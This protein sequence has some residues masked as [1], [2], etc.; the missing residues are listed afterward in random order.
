[1]SEQN[2]SFRDTTSG[3]NGSP[4]AQPGDP[5]TLAATG[6]DT[7][8]GLGSPLW[9][10]LA[11]LFFA[12]ATPPSALASLS[13]AHP[14]SSPSSRAVLAAWSGTAAS[15]GL[16]LSHVTVSITRD[17]QSSPVY[18]NLTAPASGST[19]FTG[20]AGA[21]YVISATAVDIGGNKSSVATRVLSVP[22]DD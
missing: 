14:P 13:L 8:T 9:P 20:T 18:S 5:S 10:A 17:G 11:S 21:T 3:S 15:G 7:V 6:Y 22:I 2:G 19:T 16:P 12:P 4:G 1:Y